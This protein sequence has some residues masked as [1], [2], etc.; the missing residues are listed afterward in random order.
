MK[1]LVDIAIYL[2]TQIQH[3]YK[4]TLTKHYKNKQ[5]LQQNKLAKIVVD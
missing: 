5:Q 1:G 2:H 4:T 3:K